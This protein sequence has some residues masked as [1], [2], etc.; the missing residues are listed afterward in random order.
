MLQDKLIKSC[1]SRVDSGAYNLLQFLLA[2]SLSM[3]AHAEAF[4]HTD[5]SS[6]SSNDGDDAETEAPTAIV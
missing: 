4:R 1:F 3:G 2:A 5:D 6:R